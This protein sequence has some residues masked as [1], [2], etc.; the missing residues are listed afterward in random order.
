MDVQVNG[1]LRELYERLE[2]ERRTIAAALRR[3]ARTLEV[4]SA[5]LATLGGCSSNPGEE[6]RHPRRPWLPRL[7]CDGLSEGMVGSRKAIRAHPTSATTG[8]S[9][10][11]ADPKTK[12][13]MTT[14]PVTTE[15]SIEI[16]QASVTRSEA[17]KPT[18]M[19]ASSGTSSRGAPARTSSPTP[20]TTVREIMF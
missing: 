14:D 2:R 9:R 19:A 15:T 6:R 11:A 8:V 13:N 4:L 5:H 20:I 18:A 10:N 1:D 3:T 7:R 16:F 12:S 17:P